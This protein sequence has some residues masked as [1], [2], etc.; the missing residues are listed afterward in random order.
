MTEEYVDVETADGE[1]V[2]YAA[3]SVSPGSSLF[4]YPFVVH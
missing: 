2:E 4:S 1:L 3:D